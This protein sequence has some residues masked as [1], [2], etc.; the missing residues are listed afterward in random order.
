M[1]KGR[2]QRFR[3][4]ARKRPPSNRICVVAHCLNFEHKR[5]CGILPKNSPLKVAA[6]QEINRNFFRMDRSCFSCFAFPPPA[7]HL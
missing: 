2:T 7:R 4:G 3:N 1:G 6:L 5:E